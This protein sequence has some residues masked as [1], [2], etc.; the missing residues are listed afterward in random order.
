M[1][2]IRVQGLAPEK[3]SAVGLFRGFQQ[4]FHNIW[5]GYKDPKP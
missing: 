5:E 3:A 1:A 4:S 2:Y